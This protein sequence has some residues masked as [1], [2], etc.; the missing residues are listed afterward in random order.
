M[1]G[2][3]HIAVGLVLVIG[4][5]AVLAARAE[6]ERRR[7][8]RSNMPPGWTWPPSP[9]MKRAGERCLERLRAAGVDWKPAP[10]TRA[11]ATPVLV[12]SMVLGGVKLTPTY[13]RPPFVMDCHLA[14]A[15]AEHGEVL[16]QLGVRELR[17]STIHEY[18]RIRLRGRTGRAL[19]RHSL[20]LAIDVY[21]VVT[22]DGERL[23]VVKRYRRGDPT[24]L[25]VERSVR[26]S[27]AFRRPLTP[28]NSP[29]SH[30]DHFHLEATVSYAE[31]RSRTA[32]LER[33]GVRKLDAM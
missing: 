2:G 21:E 29:R 25:A 4:L 15:L 22:D 20:G 5:T 6:A 18:R 27:L 24:L 16:R 17:F 7:G 9:A 30:R 13:R 10:R 28:G 19:S 26:S 12:P 31:D 32:A 33:R 11:V 23:E 8:R 3:R 14:L 1:R